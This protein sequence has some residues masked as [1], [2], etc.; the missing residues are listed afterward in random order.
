MTPFRLIVFRGVL[1][2][3][4]WIP[5]FGIWLHRALVARYVKNQRNPYGASSRFFTP[6][7]LDR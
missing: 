7:D 5:S 6:E 4:G 2:L 3:L 1:L